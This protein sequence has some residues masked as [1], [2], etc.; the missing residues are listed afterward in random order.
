MNRWIR[1]IGV[2]GFAFFLVKGLVWLG[3]FAIG[4]M[5]AINAVDG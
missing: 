2:L 5:A 4:A 3:V 1:R